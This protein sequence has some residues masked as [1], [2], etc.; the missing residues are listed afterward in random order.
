MTRLQLVREQNKDK[1]LDIDMGWLCAESGNRFAPVPSAFLG[2]V[3]AQAEA[4][5]SG[6][7]VPFNPVDDAPIEAEVA[8]GGLSEGAIRVSLHCLPVVF[9]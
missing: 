1:P 9:Q 2:E 7:F 6:V 3:A 5:M 8:R 4:A